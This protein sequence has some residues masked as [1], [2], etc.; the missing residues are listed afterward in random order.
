MKMPEIKIHWMCIGRLVEY[1]RC[2]MVD[3]TLQKK[4][5]VTLKT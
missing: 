4:R 5:S 3:L 1:V 2:V